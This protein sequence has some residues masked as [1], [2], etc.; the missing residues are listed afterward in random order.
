[1]PAPGVVL[2]GVVQIQGSACIDNFQYYKFEFKGEGATEWSFLKRF[3]E[4]VGSGVLGTWD[5]SILPA[6]TYRFR[7]VVVDN[8]GNFPEPCEVQVVVER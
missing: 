4:P 2:K 8:T 3:D 1:Y 5:T 7:L 6:G